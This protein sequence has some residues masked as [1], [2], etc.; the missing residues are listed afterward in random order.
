M[1]VNRKIILKNLK[2]K[3]FRKE[4]KHHIYFHHEYNGKETGAYTFLSHSSSFKD[5][6]GDI[7]TQMRKQ[8]RLDTNRE[9]VEFVSMPY[10]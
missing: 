2:K 6:A 1:K 3:G 7:L 5:I 9:A 8:L 4:K 10:R